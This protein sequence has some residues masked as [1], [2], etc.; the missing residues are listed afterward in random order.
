MS[1]TKL[2]SILAV[3]LLLSNLV[4]VG[5]IL[6]RKPPRPDREGPRRIIIEK[7]HFDEAQQ[8]QYD[9]LIFWHRTEI[10]KAEDAV[11][12]LKGQL[13]QKLSGTDTT[14]KDSLIIELGK[15]QEHIEQVHFKHFTDIKHLCRPDQM[16]YYEK[17][18]HEIAELFAPHGI[19]RKHP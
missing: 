8:K 16:G 13:Y 17:L 18:T 5:Y 12:Q 3:G 11:M 10:G 14:G 2:V 1:R 4:L 7:L 9:D 6:F 19:N 15:M